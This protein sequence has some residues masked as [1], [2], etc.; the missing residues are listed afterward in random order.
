MPS[1]AGGRNTGL[2]ERCNGAVARV[3]HDDIETP[4]RIRRRL[5][6]YAD[7]ILTTTEQEQMRDL[8]AVILH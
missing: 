8:I 5:R 1:S 4:E 3:I 7:R 2:L 6:H